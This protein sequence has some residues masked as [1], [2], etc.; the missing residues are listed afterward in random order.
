MA[1]WSFDMFNAIDAY[2]SIHDVNYTRV[3]KRTARRLH[4]EGR[5]IVVVACNMWPFSM[6][7][8][9]AYVEASEDFDKFVDSYAYWN[10]NGETGRYPAYYV[11]K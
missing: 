6:W 2:D 7:R 9:E 5:E 10:C 4:N 3:T 8:Y 11:A 1:D